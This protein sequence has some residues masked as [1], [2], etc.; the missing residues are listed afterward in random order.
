MKNLDKE[1]QISRRPSEEAGSV[2]IE[3]V[4]EVKSELVSLAED[5]AGAE[6]SPRIELTK[7]EIEKEPKSTT[8]SEET[9]SPSESTSTEAGSYAVGMEEKKAKEKSPSRGDS[10]I[11]EEEEEKVN[12]EGETGPVFQK[13]EL[14]LDLSMLKDEIVS[15]KETRAN[16]KVEDRE[17]E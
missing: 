6:A 1:E 7:K 14:N 5:K 8:S 16:L 17:H 3:E 13:S 9:R 12:V 2:E 11:T 10:I 4:S 15:E